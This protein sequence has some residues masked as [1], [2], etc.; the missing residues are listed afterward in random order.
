MAVP[1]AITANKRLAQHKRNRLA[2]TKAID[3]TEVIVVIKVTVEESSKK[4]NEQKAL[5]REIIAKAPQKP[6]RLNHHHQ[7]IQDMSLKTNNES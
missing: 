6:Q 5:A 1:D 4:V 3:L 2:E 7:P